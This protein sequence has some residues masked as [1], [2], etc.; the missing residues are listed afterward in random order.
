MENSSSLNSTTPVVEPVSPALSDYP[1]V[2]VDKPSAK[3]VELLKD[4][5]F[6]RCEIMTSL[7]TYL[8]QSWIT[9]PQNLQLS[10]SLHQIALAKLAQLNALSKAIVAHGGNPN[11]SNSNG[12]YW[13]GAYVCHNR[14]SA[15]FL[16]SNIALEKHIIEKYRNLQNETQNANLKLLLDQLVSE[17]VSTIQTFQAYL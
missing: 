9:Y 10:L 3:M 13:S 17:N 4:I 12:A 14:C 7:T 2:N 11:F 6:S 16:T 15:T 5:T 1:V 8:Y